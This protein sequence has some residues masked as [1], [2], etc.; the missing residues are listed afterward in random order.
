MMIFYNFFWKLWILFQ[1]LFCVQTFWKGHRESS[2]ASN[3]KLWSPTRQQ[4][5]QFL[6]HIHRL[7]FGFPLVCR[8]RYGYMCNAFLQPLYL[9]GRGWRVVWDLCNRKE[10]SWL[11]LTLP[12]SW[13]TGLQPCH[14]L[15]QV[16]WNWISLVCPTLSNYLFIYNVYIFQNDLIWDAPAWSIMDY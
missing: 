10:I 9:Q 13:A 5:V 3:R 7:P 4:C 2:S 8:G 14:L 12:P 1:V 11:G 15:S 6:K 16:R